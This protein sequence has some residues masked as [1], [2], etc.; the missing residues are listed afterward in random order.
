MRPRLALLVAG[1]A[2]VLSSRANAREAELHIGASVFTKDAEAYDAKV[3]LNCPSPRTARVGVGGEF[4]AQAPA[5]LDVSIDG[6]SV[7][8]IKIAGGA[9]TYWLE[10]SIPSGESHVLIKGSSLGDG[11]ALQAN[12][13][14]IVLTD[15]EG[16]TVKGACPDL[17]DV[18][19]NCAA[20]EPFVCELLST[21]SSLYCRRLELDR[22][23]L[24][25]RD[26]PNP[27]VDIW[28]PQDRS[29][30]ARLAPEIERLDA[31]QRELYEQLEA[32]SR[33]QPRQL[34]G[35]LDVHRVLE[36]GYQRA[37]AAIR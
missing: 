23:A 27:T 5:E 20:L 14:G 15:D 12:Y 31:R 29:A 18:T 17:A 25:Y 21:E 9:P 11:V 32:L 30:N 22:I 7:G 24:H 34:K 6:T 19:L 26:Y 10:V 8:A 37:L 2:C 28:T 16:C 35:Y 36:T 4:D 1:L 3:E 33:K 13:V